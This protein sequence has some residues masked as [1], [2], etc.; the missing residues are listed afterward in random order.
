MA[1]VDEVAGVAEEEAEALAA[2]EALVVREALEAREAEPFHRLRYSEAV[3]AARTG[4]QRS[5]T[6]SRSRS[7]C[8]T[9]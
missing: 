4:L 5:V 1:E 9:Y 3:A 8:R 7:R 2:V 6:T